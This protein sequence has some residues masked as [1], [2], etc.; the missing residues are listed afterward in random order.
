MTPPAAGT[1]TPAVTEFPV[2]MFRDGVWRFGILPVADFSPCWTEFTPAW[3]EP[4]GG[5]TFAGFTFAGA[6][7]L[8]RQRRLGLDAGVGVGA[9][10]G[11]IDWTGTGTS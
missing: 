3:F 4:T 9:D 6:L 8:H 11:W 7:L 5:L 1:G 2:A 10:C